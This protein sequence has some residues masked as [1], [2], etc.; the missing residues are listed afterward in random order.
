MDEQN[1]LELEI[2]TKENLKLKPEKVKI[3][4]VKTEPAGKG[5][6]VRLCVKHPE[7]EELIEISEVKHENRTGKLEMSGLWVNLDDDNKIRKHSVLANFLNFMKVGKTIDLVGK[8]V[9]TIE[10]ENGFL[11]V[12]GY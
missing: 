11:A 10:K 2:G 12:K 3:V 8:E 5:T 9:D 6:L 4:Q 7:K 1:M